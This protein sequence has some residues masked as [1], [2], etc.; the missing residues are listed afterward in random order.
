[1]TENN[2]RVSYI[3]YTDAAILTYTV[4]GLTYI[5]LLIFNSIRCAHYCHYIYV[6]LTSN[7]PGSNNERKKNLSLYICRGGYPFGLT[8]SQLI[9]PNQY[10]QSNEIASNRRDIVYL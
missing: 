10:T 3:V 1:M 9:A 5:L 4:I 2:N 7:T 6:G 8:F